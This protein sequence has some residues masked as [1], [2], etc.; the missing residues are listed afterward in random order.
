MGEEEQMWDEFS[1][2]INLTVPAGFEPWI[3]S[4]ESYHK[5][6]VSPSVPL[7]NQ[8]KNNNKKNAILLPFK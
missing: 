6:T 8:Q 3:P 1:A 4:H 7:K 2:Q 5:T